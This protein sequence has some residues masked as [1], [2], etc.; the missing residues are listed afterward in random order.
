MVKVYSSLTQQPD[1]GRGGVLL[2]AVLQGPRVLPSDGPSLPEGPPSR[3]GG[4]EEEGVRG[5]A[6]RGGLHLGLHELS[7]RGLGSAAQLRAQEAHTRQCL[8]QAPPRVEISARPSLDL[9][10]PGGRMRG[11]QEGGQGRGE[12][13]SS[14]E[15]REDPL[16]FT[17]GLWP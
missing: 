11:G 3:E 7:E 10:G 16:T 2:H 14:Q 15:E 17:T 6:C 13:Q 1:T 5:Q 12:E 9:D 4:S 8:L